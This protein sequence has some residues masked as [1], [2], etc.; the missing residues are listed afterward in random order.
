ME[1]L[2]E[3][4]KFEA[5][6]L[7]F[8]LFFGEKKFFAREIKEVYLPLEIEKRNESKRS[9]CEK[10]MTLAK[11]LQKCSTITTVHS[12]PIKKRGIIRKC[13]CD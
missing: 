13:F 2:F 12:K 3:R 6:A 4:K 9:M 5:R 8:L 11:I 1:K 10:M 7:N